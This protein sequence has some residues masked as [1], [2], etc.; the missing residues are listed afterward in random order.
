MNLQPIGDRIMIQVEENETKSDSGILIQRSD[1]F[2]ESKGK[3]I[4]TGNEDELKRLNLKIG[5]TIIID[6]L[7][8]EEFRD[9]DIKLK[10]LGFEHIIAKVIDQAV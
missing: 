8:G 4:S 2:D 10:V 9:K 6:D 5:D 7:G 3:I 1:E